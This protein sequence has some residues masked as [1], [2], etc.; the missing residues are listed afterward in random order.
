[1]SQLR[2]KGEIVHTEKYTDKKTGEEKKKY[3]KAG[4]LFM[5]DDGTFT[6]KMF[7]T[8]FNVYPPKETNYDEARQAAESQ[9]VV[10]DHLEDEI[11]F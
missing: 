7:D 5:R 9:E 4:A 11:P 3:T 8:W 2:F 6:V 10:N 1:M